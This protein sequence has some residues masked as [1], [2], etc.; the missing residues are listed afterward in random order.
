ML[1]RGRS[2][3]AVALALPVLLPLLALVPRARIERADFVL[4]NGSEVTTLEMASAYTSFATQGLWAEPFL[5][6]RILDAEGNVIYEHE[7]EQKRVL[8]ERVAA[9]ALR[10]LRDV[11]TSKGTASRA[12]IGPMNS[13]RAT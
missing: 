4:N 11:P 2:W 1:T 8:D 13:Q 9:A 12:N 6:S 5:I 7:I 10:P 3:L